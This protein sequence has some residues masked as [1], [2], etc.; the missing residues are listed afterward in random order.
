MDDKSDDVDLPS[1]ETDG[2]RG[3]SS[4]P[5]GNTRPPPL[6]PGHPF[7]SSPLARGQYLGACPV[8]AAG[9]G[10][11]LRAPLIRVRGGRVAFPGRPRLCVLPPGEPG[12]GLPSVPTS[13]VLRGM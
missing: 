10:R 6:P 9:P 7:R 4:H 13:D 3:C 5:P 12:A 1:E 8:L 2:S 11:A